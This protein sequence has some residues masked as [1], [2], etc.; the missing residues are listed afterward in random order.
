MMPT[1]RSHRRKAPTAAPPAAGAP[2]DGA[3]GDEFAADA[4]PAVAAFRA[5]LE[6]GEDWYPTLLGAIGSWLTA[7][8]TADGEHYR[9]L[10]AGEA[11]DW[12]RLAERLLAEVSDLVPADEAERLLLF[13]LPPGG[14]DDH[15]FERGIGTQKHSAHLNFQYGVLVEEALLLS[16]EQELQKA[17]ALTGSEGSAAD[18][19][20]YERAYGKPFDELMG[21]YRAET[22]SNVGERMALADLHAFTYWCSKYRLR[23]GEPARVAS[24]TRKALALLSTMEPARA[25]LGGILIDGARE[26]VVEG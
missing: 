1:T 12:L 3:A 13:A 11:F 4:G 24:D 26:I 14:L 23:M 7:E 15:E 16:A 8:E 18:V 19:A 22:G 6:G 21:I 25:R 17:G 10:L 9:Y 5:A 2:E 20:A